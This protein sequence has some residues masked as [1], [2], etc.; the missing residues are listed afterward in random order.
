MIQFT[1]NFNISI[2]ALIVRAL[3]SAVVFEF[4]RLIC[5]SSLPSLGL[6]L[7]EASRFGSSSNRSCMGMGKLIIRTFSEEFQILAAVY[8]KG[9]HGE[10]CH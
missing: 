4:D 8:H 7:F 1:K 5:R 10:Y 9:D 3:C 6:P 2:I